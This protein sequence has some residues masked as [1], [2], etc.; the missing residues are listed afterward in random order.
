MG[1]EDS[2]LTLYIDAGDRL[3][4]QPGSM[5]RHDLP[6]FVPLSTVA[7]TAALAREVGHALLAAR[8]R[9]R[10]FSSARRGNEIVND[11]YDQGN[12]KSVLDERRWERVSSLIDY[13]VPPI[14]T[15]RLAKIDGQIG[16][17]TTRDYYRFR[18]KRL[19][20]L[21]EA[22]A[23]DGDELV[24]LG[25]GWGV[26]LFSLALAGR[27]RSLRGFDVSPNGVRATNEAAA[28]FGIEAVQAEQLDLTAHGQHGFRKIE[29][30]TAFTYLCLEQ[31]KYSTRPVIDNLLQ[32]G[33]RKVIHFEPTPE[34]FSRWR[35][36]DLA[37]RFYLTA[38]DYQNNLLTTLRTLEKQGRLRIT[39][40]ARLN[41]S[42]RAVNDPTLIVW[43]PA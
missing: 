8:S 27:W 30:A 11:E 15:A 38:H 43:E 3:I 12:W 29:G 2:K 39:A 33:V 6:S 16:R 41:F 13:V 37:N 34:L 4:H 35:L 42:P 18:L 31:L 9:L 36:G 21:V 22:H 14:D 19:H 20:Q 7:S 1:G 28:H 17:V 5:P 10:R 40:V 26:N 25:C 32:S 24:E 23:T